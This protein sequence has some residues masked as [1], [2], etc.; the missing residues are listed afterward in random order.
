MRNY[1]NPSELPQPYFGI[2]PIFEMT[3]MAGIFFNSM[4]SGHFGSFVI[5]GHFGQKYRSF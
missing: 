1:P 5:N 2:D 3:K 4:N